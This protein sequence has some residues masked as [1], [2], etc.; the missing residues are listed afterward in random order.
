[1]VEVRVL[2]GGALLRVGRARPGEVIALPSG[3]R[4]WIHEV[5]YWAQFGGTRDQSSWLAYAGFLLLGTGAT[6]MFMVVKVD[7][8]RIVTPTPAGVRTVYALRA[9]RF[10]PLFSEEFETLVREGER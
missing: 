4:L 3:A 7:T 6:L 1:E 10:A 9:Q 8:A 5:R 2:R